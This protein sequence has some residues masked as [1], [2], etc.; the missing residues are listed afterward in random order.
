M[1]IFG[2][3][4]ERELPDLAEQGVRTRFIGRR[5]RAP[6]GLREQMERSRRRRPATTAL[7]LDRV[8]LRRPRRARRGGAPA[9]R[10]RRPAED[11]DEDAL[12][13]QL[14]APTCPTRTS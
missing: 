11:V 13:A 12:A 9:R 1:E 6:D 7:A 4:I 2:E 3:T 14:Y 10:G 5:D 8:R